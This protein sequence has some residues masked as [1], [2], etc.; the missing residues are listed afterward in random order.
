LDIKI[1]ISSHINYYKTTLPTLLDSLLK[2][3]I[4]EPEIYIA[5]GGCP[6][7]YYTEQLAFGDKKYT[8]IRC[9]FINHNSFDYNGLIAVVEKPY[10]SDYWLLL[11]DT[12]KVGAKFRKLVHNKLKDNQPLTVCLQK[13]LPS[14]NIGLYAQEYITFIADVLTLYKNNDKKFY[15]ATEDSLFIDRHIHY[16]QNCDA[17]ATI[18]GYADVYGTGTPREVL[19]YDA[20]D[21]FKYKANYMVKKEYTLN[22]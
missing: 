15:V 4:E 12:C 21:A 2:A 10:T 3:G 7:A 14:A 6:N 13:S 18:K 17:K 19:Y 5:I 22:A 20:M 9:D 1:T 11:H 8:N 16:F